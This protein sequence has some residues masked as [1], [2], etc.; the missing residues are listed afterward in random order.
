MTNDGRST[1][2]PRWG[3]ERRLE[4]IDFR[5]LWDRRINRGEIVE[6]FGISIQQASLDIARYLEIAPNNLEYDKRDKV[7]KATAN[8]K[9]VLARP[10]AE[11]LLNQLFALKAGTLAPS[12]SFVGSPLAHD[13]VVLP[14][15]RIRTEILVQVLSAIRAAEEIEIEYQS[16]RRPAATK[17]W[18]AP[19]AIAFDGARWHARAWCQEN[20]D[21]R[22]FVISRILTVADTRRAQV[23][24]QEDV[25]WNT[26]VNVALRP[27]KGLTAHQRSAV[28]EDF[29][30][31]DGLLHISIRQALV[32]YLLR[33][34]H[35]DSES[36]QSVKAQPIELVNKK[37]LQHLVDEAKQKTTATIQTRALAHT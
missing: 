28:E 36:E 33:Q 5:L 9:A 34:L 18:I 17:R 13:I 19:H 21:F 22:D 15:R 14:T 8:F 25:R 35:L 26:Y 23:T 4:F 24:A 1:T 30:M 6:Y 16:M 10:D 3:Q 29:G 31:T 7:Y 2:S 20:K 11:T 32:F 12:L 27:R 37:E